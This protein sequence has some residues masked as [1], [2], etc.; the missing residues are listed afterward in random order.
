MAGA[1]RC[2]LSMPM[3]GRF[4]AIPASVFL[5]LVALAYRAVIL[6]L[7]GCRTTPANG[8]LVGARLCSAMCPPE[9]FSLAN[10]YHTETNL[11]IQRVFVGPRYANC[12][13]RESWGASPRVNDDGIQKRISRNNL[14]KG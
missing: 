2:R 9:A 7:F 3:I 6:G 12:Y 14:A 13:F 11:A 5:I 10:C 8:I 1:D 4:I